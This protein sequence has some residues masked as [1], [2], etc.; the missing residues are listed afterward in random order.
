[1]V[2][3]QTKTF[4]WVGEK[5]VF[6]STSKNGLAFFKCEMQ[7]IRKDMVRKAEST[8][9][10]W[11]DNTLYLN[12]TNK[13]SNNCGFCIR[14][15]KTGVGGFNLRLEKEPSANKVISE[16]ERVIHSKRWN[17]LVFCGFG[18]P[19]QRLDLLLEITQWVRQHYGRQLTIRVDTNGH[20][21]LLNP[22]RNV[23]KELKAAGVNK[24]SVSL[25]AANEGSY[26]EI[27]KPNFQNAYTAVLDF[28]RKSRDILDVEV[29]A[30]TIPEVDLREVE[31]VAKK[32]G[33]NFRLRQYLPCFW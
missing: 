8:T 10:Y 19:T 2:S 14:N 22:R 25:N 18:E 13:C 16:L 21:Y 1:M 31:A 12:I 17:E 11:L 32:L 15:F 24:V 5:T 4:A 26:N 6:C 20:G 27:C 23:A 30:V 9:V 33:V 7:I 3:G 29:T 28:I